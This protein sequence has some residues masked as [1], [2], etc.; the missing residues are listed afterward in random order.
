M[1]GMVIPLGLV[2]LAHVGGIPTRASFTT[3]SV[4]GELADRSYSVTWL[5]D[6]SDL[7]GIFDFYYQSANIPPGA[8]IGSDAFV[9]VPIPTGQQVAIMEPSD[10]LIWDT[11]VVPAGSYYLYAIATDPPLDP[12]FGAS[13]APVTVRHPGD[14][15][16]PALVVD[17]PDAIGDT[18]AE[19]F[20]VRFRAR[21]EGPL[22]ATLRGRNLTPENDQPYYEIGED[23]SLE[24][25]SPGSFT[26]CYLWDLRALVEGQH[27]VEVRISDQAGRVY[28]AYSRTMTVSLAA[29][30]EPP[31]CAAPDPEADA[32]PLRSDARTPNVG[33]PGGCGCVVGRRVPGRLGTVFLVGALIALTFS[34]RK[35]SAAR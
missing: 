4:L 25:V 20:A 2:V 16:W 11:T 15:L 28:T 22:T 8:Q 10:A 14:P 35:R 21:G 12:L 17:E 1:M 18:Q 32:N 26:G 29:D 34:L 24:E 23:I 30:G 3:P 6:D 7:T 19:L 9:G 27:Y 31:T 33:E 5:D 13:A